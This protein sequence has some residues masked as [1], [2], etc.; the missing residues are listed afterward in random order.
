MQLKI[1]LCNKNVIGIWNNSETIV[2]S[3]TLRA[4]AFKNINLHANGQMDESVVG[5]FYLQYIYIYIHIKI[6]E[7]LRVV[8]FLAR[9]GKTYKIKQ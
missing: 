5:R 2:Y 6:N 7:S 8:H 4:I 1:I 9:E 3:P